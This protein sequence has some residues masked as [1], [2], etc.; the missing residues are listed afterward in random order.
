M[1]TVI[2]SENERRRHVA[3]GEN[4]PPLFDLCRTIFVSKPDAGG[5]IV[6]CIGQLN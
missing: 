5:G 6:L 4:S 1:H 2:N 3:G